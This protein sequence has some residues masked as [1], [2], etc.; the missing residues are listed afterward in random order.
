MESAPTT[1]LMA[2]VP[3][4]STHRRQRHRETEKE[5]RQRH[6][7]AFARLRKALNL[8]PR[9]DQAT[10]LEL[11]WQ[12]IQQPQAQRD[13]G[14]N[15][16]LRKGHALGSPSTERRCSS[17][18][19]ITSA[20]SSSPSTLE[21]DAA[22]V[23]AAL[24][25]STAF[26]KTTAFMVP[27]SLG[28]G[29]PCLACGQ[30]PHA[31]EQ[32]QEQATKTVAALSL[33]V[34][35]LEM[36]RQE[37]VTRVADLERQLTT[38]STTLSTAA[39]LL[40]TSDTATA[41]S[42]GVDVHHNMGSVSRGSDVSG[43]GSGWPSFQTGA[44]RGHLYAGPSSTSTMTE[45]TPLLW[46]ELGAPDARDNSW[47]TLDDSDLTPVTTTLDG[48]AWLPESQVA[49]TAVHDTLRLVDET[50]PS[51]SFNRQSHLQAQPQTR[52]QPQAQP[53]QNATS[54][55]S[56]PHDTASASSSC[57]PIRA[58][59]RNPTLLETP[60]LSDSTMMAIVDEHFQMIY[61]NTTTFQHIQ[62]KTLTEG[63]RFIQVR[64]F[65]VDFDLCQDIF[66][67]LMYG[68]QTTATAIGKIRTMAGALVWHRCTMSVL[69]CRHPHTGW[70]AKAMMIMAEIVPP[71]VHK[72]SFRMT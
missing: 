33:R 58:F 49:N 5:R 61:C 60:F 11:A 36:E 59:S 1:A 9:T 51:A 21:E 29:R 38:T 2:E 71:P 41:T 37:F 44:A 46:P 64:G 45:T 14:A 28:G 31:L 19:S 42:S 23:E 57:G 66:D 54:D 16:M 53:Q 40:T 55:S 67:S 3:A 4:T 13:D 39:N 68:G 48:N 32:Q 26:R 72:R 12:R 6:N 7:S 15:N 50:L 17:P 22:H 47:L 27:P 20:C 69:Q 24:G 62:A 56:I 35:Q 18:C 34:S 52:L 63:M 70:D 10:V 30:L 65:V 25:S 43:I 8:P